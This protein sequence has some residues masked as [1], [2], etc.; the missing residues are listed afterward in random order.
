MK[1]NKK[2]RKYIILSGVLFLLL[3]SIL[4]AATILIHK[5]GV[6]QYLLKKVCTGYG[7]ETK[8]GKMDLTIFGVFGVVINDVEICRMDQ[9]FSI[10]AKS[11]TVNFSKMRLLMGKVVPVSVDI[12]HPVIKISE[13]YITPPMKKKKVGGIRMPILCSDGVNSFNIEEGE[14]LIDGPSGITIDNI[15]ATLEHVEG[16]SSSFKISGSGRA[17]YKGERSE[18]SIKS[19]VDVNPNDILKSVFNASLKT[20]NTPL[21][22]IPE[23]SK[24]IDFNKGH[25][26][27]DLNISGDPLK[28]VSLGGPLK[29]KSSAFILFHKGRSKNYDIPEVNG[30]ITALVKD[31]VIR[32]DSL[33]V[34]NQ[35]LNIDLDMMLD[36]NNRDDPYFK[37][38]A[39]SEFMSVDTFRRN[40]PFQ[41]TKPWLKDDLFPMFQEGLVRI[42]KLVLNGTV[43]QFRHIRD[44]EN[45][46][47][48]AMSLT[49]KSF[50][51]SNMGIQVPVTGISASVDI[52][53]GNLK[54]SVLSGVFGDSIIKE[55]S[56]DVDGMLGGHSVFTIFVDGDFD[57]RE[58]MS[59]REL[60]V[61]PEKARQQI[62]KYAELDGRL[63]ARTTIGYQKEQGSPR[64]L[65]GDYSFNDT[66]YHK[67]Y[68]GLP[69]RFSQI[70]FHFPDDSANTFSGQGV[71]G[72][73]HFNVTGVTES[74]GSRIEIKRAEIAA[75][76][77][78]TQLIQ[79]CLKTDKSP[80]KFKRYLPVKIAVDVQKETFTYKGNID[81]EKLVM[82]SDELIFNSTGK[83]NTISFYLTQ[84]GKGNLDLN[85]AQFKIGSS[86]L[87]LT[88]QYSLKDKK[89]NA[90]KLVSEELTIGDLG[91]Q[92][93][94]PNHALFGRLKGSLD[95]EFPKK[96]IKG[97]QINGSLIG[98]DISFIPG[99]LPLP[100]RE[101]SFG[102]DL[103][104]EKGFIKQLDM[105]F[106]EY[107]L[108][109]KGILNGWDSLKGDLLVTSDYIDLTELIFGNRKES[110]GKSVSR[111]KTL[112]KEY[113]I[114]L[115][116][117]STKGTWRKLE[118]AGLNADINFSE[119]STIIKNAQ[120]ELEKG[121]VAI[122]GLIKKRSPR[123]T[124][125][126]AK[127]NLANQPIDK[128]ISDSGFGDLNVKGSLTLKSSL[129]I[130]GKN[131]DGLLKNLSGTID[132]M[133]IR[134]GLIKNSRV[135]IKVLDGL[136]IP[137]KFTERPP[138]MRE[139]GFYFK[140]IEGAGIIEKGIFKTD[141][142][143]IKS[144]VF[145]AVGFGE[146]NL[147]EKTHSIR[148][149]IQPLTNLD[150]II[151][152]IPIVGHIISDG[153]ETIFTVG[154]DVEGPWKE[155]DLDY[156][157]SENFKSLGGVI[158]RV[159]L[160]PIRLIKKVS[161]TVENGKKKTGPEVMDGNNTTE[162]NEAEVAERP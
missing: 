39:K 125:I 10:T 114:N 131:D 141:E 93:K 111:R 32:I 158:K 75:N 146:E 42:D 60:N 103:S 35:N 132:N 4:S 154:Y 69:L 87:F 9:S 104:G 68:L 82:E 38:T 155:P 142:F 8:T 78:F 73:T 119:T 16:T 49:C 63:S 156:L 77:D 18:F 118:F 40:Y 55:G 5:P 86:K 97:M 11:L 48:F 51:M 17:G 133:V 83:G 80:Y 50:T 28:G 105:K 108:H 89:L 1:F 6:Q 96:N 102:L 136:N 124:D 129:S 20:E 33:N 62:E 2:I 153:N 71:F 106:G 22:W 66:L 135:F 67:R 57:I 120:A 54:I 127:I 15:S 45:H 59:Y 85:S 92:F 145:N 149:L 139:E 110:A 99:P 151:N 23:S 123:E 148:L 117:N 24:K 61:M 94:G 88:G 84:H 27:M 76:A 70:N 138:D 14:L 159:F 115:K 74:S 152:K 56:I 126:S 7:L 44:E 144:P 3:I 52:S 36:L 34:N 95:F 47:I 143:I 113:D 43:D 29:F 107:P 19:T 41:L 53:D 147:Y 130:K 65:S 112:F 37:L 122:N 12:K 90:L 58:L 101:C 121:D 137:D 25:V 72:N 157:P 116:I 21:V 64:V 162:D 91:I 150:Y 79:G 98:N 128:L 46:S 31:K 134:K 160:T 26:S 81:A 140:S 30:S 161:N 109:M 13:T 100:V